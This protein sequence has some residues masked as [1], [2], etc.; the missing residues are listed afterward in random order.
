MR[1]ALAGNPNSGKTTLLNRLTG[2]RQRVGNFPG[3]TVE[4]VEGALRAD[5]NVTLIDLPGVY[6]LDAAEG[7]EAVARETLA[8]E[9]LDAVIN[10]LDATSMA[11]GLYL[12]LELKATGLPVLVALTMLDELPEKGKEI[13]LPELERELG[14]PVV[15]AQKL[16]AAL[17][18]LRPHSKAQNREVQEPQVPARG[19]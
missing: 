18:K 15:A 11:R 10:V 1:I 16:P 14:L 6:A 19:C 12:T 5:G 17:K 8:R 3:V 4:R 2:M 13:N 9:A 7:E